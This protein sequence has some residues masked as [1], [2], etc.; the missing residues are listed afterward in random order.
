MKGL[1]YEEIS[2]TEDVELVQNVIVCA[3]VIEE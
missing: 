3:A 1:V 2:H